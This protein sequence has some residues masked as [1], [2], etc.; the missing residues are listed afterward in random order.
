MSPLHILFLLV[1]Y[2]Q[3]S[4]ALPLCYL[5]PKVFGG[6]NEDTFFR[7]V[8]VN[9]AKDLIVAGGDTGD[10]SIHSQPNGRKIPIIV[11]YSIATSKIFWAIGL[12]IHPY[13]PYS[14][15]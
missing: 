14:V 10:S 11:A 12:Q 2:H 9:Y 4:A 8:D 7:S 3:I 1:L 13:S 5:F 15:F 6:L